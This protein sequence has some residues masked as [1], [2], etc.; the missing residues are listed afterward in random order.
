MRF[1]QSMIRENR[2]QNFDT[3][4]HFIKLHQGD[5]SERDIIVKQ[6]MG[7]AFKIATTFE[8]T[9]N[10]TVE[11]YFSIALEY[12]INA[13]NNFDLSKDVE[14]S[15]YATKCIRC[16]IMRFKS[17]SKKHECSSLNV[18]FDESNNDENA[19]LIDFL[20][21]ENDGDD[22]QKIENKMEFEVLIP[23]LKNILTD[24]EFEMIKL[25][26]GF[27]DGRCWKYKEIAQKFGNR[28]SHSFIDN[29]LRK[30]KKRLKSQISDKTSYLSYTKY[31]TGLFEV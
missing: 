16:G 27:V 15:T 13:V 11:E 22:Y 26:Y 23:I 17:N 6:W 7:L 5:E 8:T 12:L 1:I 19:C 14:F 31:E 25:R 30:I 9:E 29:A 4:E 3:K 28:S 2:T 24:K 18:V 21:D 10:C 20:V